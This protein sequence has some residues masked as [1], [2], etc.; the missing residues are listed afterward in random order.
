MDS[1]TKWLWV[2]A[3]LIGGWIGFCVAGR[4]TSRFWV[5]QVCVLLCAGMFVGVWAGL[6][7]CCP[8]IV[9]WTT[10]QVSSQTP[11]KLS[12]LSV[13]TED[14]SAKPERRLYSLAISV[15]V[16][17]ERFNHLMKERFGQPTDQ[18]VLPVLTIE[19]GALGNGFRHYFENKIM[20]TGNIRQ[21]DG[22]L[23]QL[24]M[25]IPIDSS[26]TMAI[27]ATQ[28]AEIIVQTLLPGWPRDE[29]RRGIDVV[30]DQ[31]GYQLAQ[32]VSA[33][34]GELRITATALPTIGVSFSVSN[35]TD[36]F[37]VP[38]EEEWIEGE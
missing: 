3:G 35:P 14:Q 12:R 17:R 24:V 8:R 36:T 23:D 34:I 5:R 6:I 13:S 1:I 31:A 38:P 2:I 27:H 21:H 26:E 7:Y 4:M 30:F 15:E 33:F 18:W 19:H 11:M 22:Q 16:F 9:G 37:Y 25:I 20:L 29:I 10:Q 28:I 32:Q